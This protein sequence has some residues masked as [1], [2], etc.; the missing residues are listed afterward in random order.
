MH[1]RPAAAEERLSATDAPERLLEEACQPEP[2]KNAKDL[3]LQGHKAPTGAHDLSSEDADAAHKRQRDSVQEREREDDGWPRTENML[4]GLIDF[5]PTAQPPA[6]ITVLGVSHEILH[7]DAPLSD[8]ALSFLRDAHV[9]CAGRKI[10]ESCLPKI[11]RDPL[12]AEIIPLKAPLSAVTALLQQRR[13]EGKRV[14]VLADGDPL[15]FGIGAT[16]RRELSPEELRIVPA[17]SS[18][19][20]ACARLRLPWHEVISISLH[21]RDDLAPL[22]RAVGLG[23]PICILTDATTPPSEIAR[24]LLDRGVDWFTASVLEKMGGEG[25]KISALSLSGMAT[26]TF[27]AG[28]TIMLE[29]S[30]PA[31]SPHLGIPAEELASEGCCMTTLPVRAAALALLAI[32]PQHVVWDIGAGT[33]AVALEACA[34]AKEGCVIAVEKRHSRAI[35]IRENRRRFGAAI[36]EVCLGNAADRMPALPDPDRVFLGGGLSGD[37][38]PALLSHICRRL[39]EGGRVVAAC[40]LLETFFFCRTFLEDKGWHVEIMHLQAAKA[41]PLAGDKHLVPNNPV[42]LIAAQKPKQSPEASADA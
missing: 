38:G 14:L 9:I 27:P 2:K 17:V 37:D 30:A 28:C 6:P 39:P 36:L 33:G 7:G 13:F 4:S 29:P 8:T 12:P 25:E 1:K 35:A 15:F 26:A 3:S 18:L 19:Q 22:N 32:E 23:R 21:G 16:L 41:A 40:V 34:L 24:H 10:L 5:E 20:Q 42:F 31:R 11:S